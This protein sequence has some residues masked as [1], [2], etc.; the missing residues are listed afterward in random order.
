M[1]RV[2][3]E[4]KDHI[5]L[6]VLTRAEKK[7]AMDDEMIDALIAAAGEVAA[8]K[9]RVVI[10]SGAGDCFCA[11]IDISGLTK[12]IG[13][14][15]EALI[16]PRSH[17]DGTT[18]RWQEVAMAWHRLEVPV[19]AALHGAVFGAGMQLALGA[20]IRIA[21]PDAQLAVMEMKWGIVPDMGGMVLLPRLVREDVM[22]RLI[23]TAEP[24][25]AKQAA[26]WG[27][28]T[29]VADDPMLAATKLAEKIALKGPNAIKAAKALC[30][31]AYRLPP[32]DVLL[33]E[34]RTQASLLGKPEQ[35]E[36]IAAQFA[37]RAPNFE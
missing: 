24:I 30:E 5:A 32:E 23:Y 8:S 25:T 1:A 9:A 33:A 29:E 12:M 21:G 13:Q 16:L 18:N 20:D 14:D 27:L 10:L 26:A 37:K 31:K 34:A 2:S 3:L 4:I 17:G 6:V 7:N 11:G 15:M 19:I 28:V 35:M 22:K 36:I